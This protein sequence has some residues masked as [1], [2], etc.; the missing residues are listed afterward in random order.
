MYF[1]HL[2]HFV[3]I[4]IQEVLTRSDRSSFQSIQ[5][6]LDTINCRIKRRIL[7]DA[8][9]NDFIFSGQLDFPENFIF[10]ST[11]QTTVPIEPQK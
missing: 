3:E 5:C 7:I 6:Q 4:E 10:D 2:F 1:E 9:L 8:L 11:N